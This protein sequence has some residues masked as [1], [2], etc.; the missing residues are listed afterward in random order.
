[1]QKVKK[2]NYF[3]TKFYLLIFQNE[4]LCVHQKKLPIITNSEQLFNITY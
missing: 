4:R 2:K 1:M 3:K